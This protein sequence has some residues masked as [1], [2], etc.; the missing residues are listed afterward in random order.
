MKR[1]LIQLLGRLAFLVLKQADRIFTGSVSGM[2]P[3]EEVRD[4]YTAFGI[5]RSR[6]RIQR[7]YMNRGWLV[8]GFEEAQTLFKDPRFSTDLRKNKFVTR[9][10]RFASNGRE[11]SF[12]DNPTMLQ[13]DPPDHT[14]LRK[15]AQQGFLHK[16]VLSL[17]PRIESIVKRCLESYDSE[18]G[19]FDIVQQ[20]ARPLPAIV[21]AEMLGL[22]EEDLDDFQDMSN[23][24]L[25]L[26]ALGDD[27]L[28]D[29]GARANEQLI[30]Y[31]KSAIEDKRKSPGQD[32]MSRLIEA[33]E[34]GD[35]LTP[36]ELYSMCVLLLVAGHETTTRLIGNGMYTLLQHPDQVEMLKQDP[37]LIPNAVEE[38]L[39]FEPPVQMMPRFAV[40]DTVFY[41]KKIKKNQMIVPVI[42]SANRDPGANEDPDVFD[43]AREDIQH[44][45]FGHGIHLCLGLNLARLEAK[46]AINLLLARFPHMTIAEQEIVWTPIPLVRGMDNLVVDVDEEAAKSAA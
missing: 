20:L 1:K 31:F 9:M 42:A 11:I 44:V 19:Q 16:Y 4:P 27:D 26:T 36:E 46:V 29:E 34:E 40:E 25:G 5:M 12:L 41:G 33:E 30:E 7:S 18:A 22:P 6:G 35:R 21:I 3:E 17:E 28:M 37:S 13:M 23:R 43:I 24:L 2:S 10:L 14:R 39:R 38:M 8:L 32:L 15:L 45:S